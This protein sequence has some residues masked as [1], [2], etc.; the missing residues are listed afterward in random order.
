MN[1]AEERFR[2]RV[3][4]IKNN[5]NEYWFGGGDMIDA[6]ILQ[7]SKRFDPDNLPEWIIKKGRAALRDLVKAHIDRFC[8]I[9]DPIKHKCIG[10]I[11][12]NHEHSMHKHHNRD[13]MTHICEKLAVK[14]LTDCFFSRLM[15]KNKYEMSIAI[16][17]FA[18][19]GNGGGRSSGSEPGHLSR[20]ASDKDCE[21][22]FRGHSHTTCILPPIQRLSIPSRGSL[23][24]SP[25]FTQ[26][27]A[28]NAGCYMKTYERGPATYDSMAN[29]P[30][31]AL[32][33]CRAKIEPFARERHKG[34]ES[35]RPKITIEE[36]VL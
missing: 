10:L 24:N 1:C 15:F 27:R 6:V 13:V 34:L 5:P 19:H 20:L 21:I 22:V 3:N 26:I 35:V 8:E 23:E 2:N 12:G 31:R 28:A 4:E 33:T 32:I 36:V 18:C 11:M 17:M 29:Y 16:R 30:V 25:I 9:V 7:D 14:N